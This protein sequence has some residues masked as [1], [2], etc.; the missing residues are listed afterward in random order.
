MPTEVSPH[1]QGLATTLLGEIAGAGSLLSTAAARTILE[2]LSSI[3]DAVF[4]AIAAQGPAKGHSRRLDA[5]PAEETAAPADP[6]FMQVMGVVDGLADSLR[7]SRSVPGEDGVVISTRAIQARSA[8][9]HL[10]ALC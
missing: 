8:S 6:R 9:A 3:V 2:S 10:S 1:A 7:Q 4:L 5:A